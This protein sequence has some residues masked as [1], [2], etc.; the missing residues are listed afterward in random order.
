MHARQKTDP[1]V[2][3]QLRALESVSADN[4]EV[5]TKRG[6]DAPSRDGAPGVHHERGETAGA[7]TADTAASPEESASS[8]PEAGSDPGTTNTS[9]DPGGT[10][11]EVQRAGQR[12]F[13]LDRRGKPLM[14]TTPRRARLLLRSGRARVHR[15]APFVIRLIDR[16]VEDSDVSP[17]VL[18]IDP[19]SRHTGLALAQERETLDRS[20]GEVTT[21]RAGI[22]LV[23]LDHRGAQIRDRLSARAALRRGR[24]SRN[25][26]HRAPRFLNRTK[27]R[28]WLAPSLR[29]RVETTLSWV[30]RLRRWAPIGRI[31]YEAVR[32]DTQAL[33]NPNIIGTEYQQGTLFGT[34]VREFI[35]ERDGRA[36]VY[37][38]A[39]GTGTGSVPLNLD[40]VI[41]RSRGGSD[42]P[43]NLVLSCIPCNQ[44][45]GSQR[46]ED[47][48]S[49][50]PA[51][52]ERV[53]R[54]RKRGL[55]DAAAVTSTRRALH[56]ALASTGLEVRAFSGGRTKWNRTRAGLGKDH[57]LDA[58][59]VGL[60]DTVSTSPGHQHVARSTGRGTYRRTL[61]D[62]HGFPRSI[63][64]RT[65]VRT[66]VIDGRERVLPRTGDIV[67]AVVPQGK[68]R[69]THVGRASVRAASADIATA[70]GKAAGIH[71]RHISVV[72]RADGYHH[73]REEVPGFLPALKGGVSS[74][75]PR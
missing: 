2:L 5:G 10:G 18:G 67:R 12:V 46:V 36:C 37:C 11:R 9:A 28:G 35:L 65:K 3:P 73:T 66:A 8:T 53:N 49:G 14:P 54:H 44:D 55:A 29:H 19:G 26:R 23:R 58:L 17:L 45:K 51:V 75:Q 74:G 25:M 6:T 42:R 70:R 41:A 68:Y 16:T 50:R 31:D 59:C 22:F 57:V 13:V 4:P 56:R 39:R 72:Q 52:L 33:E 40:H 38:H 20:T 71:H 32:F 64:P 27:P 47:F 34:E 63:L 1:G 43:S 15:A 30:E 62:R 69:G 60:V 24:R 7:A 48:L 21:D 61:T